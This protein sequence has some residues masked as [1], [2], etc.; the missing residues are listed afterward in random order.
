M[1]GY[2]DWNRSRYAQWLAHDRP[3]SNPDS[4]SSSE[5]VQTVASSGSLRVHAPQPVDLGRVPPAR[6]RV[7]R[8]VH[9][10]DD[11]H[12]DRVHVGDGRM[13]LDEDVAEAAERLARR[14]HDRDVEQG[15]ARLSRRHVREHGANGE[16]HVVE[17]VQDGRRRLGRGEQRD[18][19]TTLLCHLCPG[20]VESVSSSMA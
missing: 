15:V 7:D 18:A 19:W 1:R 8:G 2:V 17:P 3:S 4:A 13:G 6:R 5:P 20:S 12:V 11:R 14:G 9:V 16:Q 10:A